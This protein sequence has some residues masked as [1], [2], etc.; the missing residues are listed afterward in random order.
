MYWYVLN[1]LAKQPK[2]M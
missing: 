1:D 2:Q